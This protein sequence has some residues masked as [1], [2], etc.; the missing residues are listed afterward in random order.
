MWL[1]V[2]SVAVFTIILYKF[3]FS[4]NSKNIFTQYGIPQ[5]DTSIAV[6][7]LDIFL[8]RKSFPDADDYAYKTMDSKKF[9]GIVEMGSPL[10]LIKDMELI[11]KVLIKDFD[12]F[13]NR[14]ELFSEA[15]IRIRKMLPWLQ[16]EEWKGVRS[17]VSPTFTT[18][19]IRRMSEYFNTVGKEWVSSL[20]EKSK[21]SPGP[22]GSLTI[23]VMSYVNQYTIDVIASA[24]FGMNA[25]T[26]KDSTSTFAKNAVTISEFTKW[27]M[28]KMAISLQLP[29]LGRMLNIKFFDEE[30]LDFFEKILDQGLKARM[31]GSTTKRN[32]FLQL[33]VEAK[34]GELKTV[35]SDELSSFEKEAQVEE[36]QEKGKV[37]KQWLTQQIM[38]SQ[39]L[40]FFF[41]GFSTTSN[42]ITCTAYALALHQDVQE[43][44]RNEVMKIMKPDGSFDYD[45]LS[46]LVYM[47]MVICEILR[48]YP[49]AARIE[50]VCL[51]DYKDAETG[52]FIPKGVTA[53][54]PVNSMHYDKKYYNNPDKFDPEHFSPDKKAERVSYAYLPFGMGPRN[55]VGMRFALVKTKAAVAHLISHFR[56]EPTEKTPVPIKVHWTGIQA[57]PPKGLEL[58]LIPLK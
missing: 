13:M 9:C 11:K 50:R 58:K 33:L 10:I 54:V 23:D 1:L 19:K 5:V 43:R 57:F 44:L 34:R 27:Q 45:D 39:S 32:D 52:L 40:V 12:N 14:R 38:N 30:A 22:G 26:I 20:I 4:T 24:V 51:N 21:E 42:A 15:E 17:S 56:I 48:M 16:G 3:F 31:S 41:A 46:T 25:G 18:G 8:G 53:A 37:K 55:C 2:I 49:A 28:I 29:K 7:K 47:D 36:K 35:G 6:S